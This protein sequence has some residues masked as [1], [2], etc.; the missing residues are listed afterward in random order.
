[1]HNANGNKQLHRKSNARYLYFTDNWSPS[2]CLWI[3]VRRTRRPGV[4]GFGQ[5][6]SD[7]GHE[8]GGGEEKKVKK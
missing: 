7:G 4:N 6:L 8:S 1:M 3:K 5:V 2:L